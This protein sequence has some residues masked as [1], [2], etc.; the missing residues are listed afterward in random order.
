MPEEIREQLEDI[1]YTF[2]SLSNYYED[3]DTKLNELY[4]EWVDK[5][6]DEE[7]DLDQAKKLLQAAY[8]I[9]DALIK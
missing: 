5:I 1:A 7:I 8:L 2:D 4:N 6:I 3:K 9:N